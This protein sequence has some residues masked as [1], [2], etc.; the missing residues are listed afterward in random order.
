MFTHKLRWDLMAQFM[1]LT[2][3]STVDRIMRCMHIWASSGTKG[4]RPSHFFW[5]HCASTYLLVQSGNFVTTRGLNRILIQDLDR[6][7]IDWKS[8]KTPYFG[9][10]VNRENN[11]KKI[12]N[13]TD[14]MYNF[15]QFA[16][17][18]R[19]TKRVKVRSLGPAGLFFRFWSSSEPKILPSNRY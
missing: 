4:M 5:R 13:S 1:K 19:T 9:S 10:L 6:A 7:P 8:R 11:N 3:I 14:R 15:E 17:R 2:A 16:Y 18:A 12:I